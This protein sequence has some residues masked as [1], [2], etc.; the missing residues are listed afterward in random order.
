M[1]VTVP[2][3][4]S[5]LTVFRLSIAESIFRIGPVHIH[6]V[7]KGQEDLLEVVT[8]CKSIVGPNGVLQVFRLQKMC[9][10]ARIS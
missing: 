6:D 4:T 1:P 10:K 9:S 5:R 7:N 2:Y 8:N 3:L